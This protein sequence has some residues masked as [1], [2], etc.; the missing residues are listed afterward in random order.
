MSKRFQDVFR[1]RS[2]MFAAIN[3]VNQQLQEIRTAMDND[4]KELDGVLAEIK[5]EVGQLATDLDV[6]LSSIEQ[7]L[8]EANASVD[9]S[10]EISEAREILDSLKA[11]DS[12]VA[13]AET[14]ASTA[15]AAEG[16]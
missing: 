8:A 7:K 10:T 16:Q 2:K 3:H 6:K 15:S 4:K 9:V 1:W 12:K 13:P 5:S 14:A 11:I